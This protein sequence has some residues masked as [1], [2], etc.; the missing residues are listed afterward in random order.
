MNTKQQAETVADH[1][2]FVRLLVQHDRV[3]RAFLRSMLPSGLD[4][5]EVMQ[6]VSVVAWRK[7][8]QLDSPEN[9]RRWVCVIARYEVLMYRRKKARDRLVLGEEIEQLIAAEGI[10]ELDLRERQLDALS[11]CLNKLPAERKKLTMLVYQSEQP[12]KQI[13]AQI[14]KTPEA[15]Y[16]VLSRTR[17]DLLQCIQRAVS[18]GD[19]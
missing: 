17:R 13:A 8:D 6:E 14:G 18:E 15:L 12:M 19:A 4:V 9:F 2:G 5:D 1:E 3:I 11:A 10:E 16:K 7:F